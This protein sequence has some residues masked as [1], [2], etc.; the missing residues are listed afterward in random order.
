MQSAA[1][2]RAAARMN[3]TVDTIIGGI[4]ARVAER[5]RRQQRH[6]QRSAFEGVVWW[7]DSGN[8]SGETFRE[9][10][11]WVVEDRKS[12]PDRSERR[13]GMR[14]LRKWCGALKKTARKF[15]ERVEDWRG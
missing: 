1:R 15:K 6:Q 5:E 8:G 4:E 9:S 3:R 12:Q 2:A 14:R 10:D 13:G 7:L 11:E